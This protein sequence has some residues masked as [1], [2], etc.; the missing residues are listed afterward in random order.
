MDSFTIFTIFCHFIANSKQKKLL[1]NTG[2][3]YNMAVLISE[4][5]EQITN[6]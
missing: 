2:H 6:P 1:G 4:T 3:E 5:V